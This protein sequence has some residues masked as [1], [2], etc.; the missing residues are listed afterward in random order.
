MSC[1]INTQIEDFSD[2]YLWLIPPDSQKFR[3]FLAVRAF[4]LD[5]FFV[6]VSVVVHIQQSASNAGHPVLLLGLW[7]TQHIADQ[8]QSWFKRE[9]RWI[10]ETLRLSTEEESVQ[11]FRTRALLTNVSSKYFKFHGC[12]RKQKAT[13]SKYLHDKLNSKFLISVKFCNQTYA[14][15]PVDRRQDLNFKLYAYLCVK[16]STM[17]N[18]TSFM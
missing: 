7:S 17:R 13:S 16:P 5:V 15:S 10:C 18:N 11:I 14:Q 1:V 6:F 8:K 3:P 12:S 2:E 9:W 4:W